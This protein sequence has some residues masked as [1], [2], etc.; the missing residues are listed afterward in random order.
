MPSRGPLF[1]GEA[2]N[3]TEAT[4]ELVQKPN[5]HYLKLKFYSLPIIDQT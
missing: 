5:I 1:F 4:D 3:I 2:K